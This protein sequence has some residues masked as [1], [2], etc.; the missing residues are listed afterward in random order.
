[1]LTTASSR[2][3]LSDDER[4]SAAPRRMAIW[5][6]TCLFIGLVT[7]LPAAVAVWVGGGA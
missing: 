4:A 5:G 2:I 6:I 1:M 3:P 7:I